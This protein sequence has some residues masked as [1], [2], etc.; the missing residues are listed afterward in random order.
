MKPMMAEHV[1][2]KE[3]KKKKIEDYEVDGAC[4]ALMRAEE[5]KGNPEMMALVQKKMA[6]KKKAIRSIQDMRQ[7]AAMMDDASED[8][9]EGE[10]D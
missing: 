9:D 5:I 8:A 1:D 7:H 10:S 2:G 3:G 4:E 6:K